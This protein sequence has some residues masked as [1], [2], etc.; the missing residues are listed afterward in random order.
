VYTYLD[1]KNVLRERTLG[2]KGNVISVSLFE[3]TDEKLLTNQLIYDSKGSVSGTVDY[4]YNSDGDLSSMTFFDPDGVKWK[5][6]RLDKWGN[7]ISYKLF[8]ENGSL[9]KEQY[10]KYNNNKQIVFERKSFLSSSFKVSTFKYDD[11]GNLVEKTSLQEN[12]DSKSKLRFDY[13]YDSNGNWVERVEYLN[14]IPKNLVERT[15]DYF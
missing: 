3:Y 10:L 5:E 12:G 7:L 4:D 15:Y 11:H 8:R 9:Q 6:E 14:G 1:D 13:L 2:Q